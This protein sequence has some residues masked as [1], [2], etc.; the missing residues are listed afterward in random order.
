MLRVGLIGYG[1][2]GQAF[3]APNIRTVPGMELACIMERSGSL[4]QQRYPNVRVVRTI[5]E[6][7]ADKGIQLCVVATPNTS[8]FDVGKQCL[9]AGRDVVIDKPFAPTLAEAEELVRLGKEN[10]RLLTVF[11]NRRLDGDFLTVKKLVDSGVLGRIAEYE[12][13]YD[14]FR[15]EP[16]LSVWREQ[17]KPGSGVMFDLSPHLIDQALTLFGQPKSITAS[18]FQQREGIVVDDAFDI[19]LQYPGLRV[20]LRGRVLAYAPG[21]HFLLHGTKGTFMKWGM[22]PQEDR[23]RNGEEPAG[24]DWG[25]EAESQW[26]TLS[27]ADG[28]PPKKIKTE[29]GDYRQFYAMMRDAIVHNVPLEITPQQSLATMRVIELA[30][31]SSR[32]G[33]TVSWE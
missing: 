9:L 33:K 17:A 12:V 32:E 5:D 23:L 28:S 29:R 21:P 22:D 11:H 27:L 24:D 25:E 2:A 18:A 6:L 26:G 16:K 31:Q 15:P 20:M 8:H 3:H 30:Y 10:K 4:A 19:C 14:R 1:L 7:L 13:R